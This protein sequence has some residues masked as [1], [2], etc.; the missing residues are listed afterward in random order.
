MCIGLRKREAAIRIALF[1]GT[2]TLGLLVHQVHQSI[3][4]NTP[5]WDQYLA[6]NQLRAEF[7]DYRASNRI[8][9]VDQ[10]EILK[11]IG[12]T[13]NDMSMLSRF[14]YIDDE[15]FSFE[16]LNEVVEQLPPG[17]RRIKA[18]YVLREIV[19]T[20]LGTRACLLWLF[21]LTLAHW[22]WRSLLI[23]LSAPIGVA[24]ILIALTLWMRN[25]P[26]RVVWPLLFFMLVCP[27]MFM[28]KGETGSRL[29][30]LRL[31][32]IGIVAA[33]V[34]IQLP[35]AFSKLSARSSIV[36]QRHRAL[37][38]TLTKIA[39]QPDQ[40][41]VIWGGAFPWTSIRPFKTPNELRNFRTFPLGSAQRTPDAAKILLEYQ[42]DDLYLSLGR[43]SDLFFI[44]R[45][46]EKLQ[47]IYTVYMR[48]HYGFGIYW[49]THW[50][51]RSFA[52]HQIKFTD[53]IL[54][55]FQPSEFPSKPGVRVRQRTPSTRTTIQKIWKRP[56]LNTGDRRSRNP[57]SEPPAREFRQ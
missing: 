57:E 18:L 38:R 9:R 46:S 22:R 14:F 26:D 1:V 37:K 27:L 33:T 25:P 17:Q 19:A 20:P 6:F 12:W 55:E 48:E 11:G 41:F 36:R 31:A 49:Q 32:L 30:G 21:C 47:E 45:Q 50:K 44:D 35:A 29:R 43:R 3:Y 10:A 15:V 8:H 5:G 23:S 16:K 2:L 51:F 40:L 34:V 42:I 52:V 54:P 7:T 4:K 24:I 28:A 56:P 53:G 39:P 13:E